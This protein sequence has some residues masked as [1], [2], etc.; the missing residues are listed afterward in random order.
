MKRLLLA[1]SLAI[2]ATFTALAG[3]APQKPEPDPKLVALIKKGAD[4]LDAAIPTLDAAKLEEAGNVFLEAIRQF[5]DSYRAA[6]GVIQVARLL[7]EKNE[8]GEAI[9]WMDRAIEISSRKPELNI[10]TADILIRAKNNSEALRRIKLAIDAAPQESRILSTSLVC[11]A[12]MGKFD[13]ESRQIAERL[14]TL[15]DG[16]LGALLFLGLWNEKH[17]NLDAARDCY[18]KAVR[19]DTNNMQARR[20][21][22][23]LYDKQ[24]NFELAEREFIKM[25]NAAPGHF[26][27]YLYLAELYKKH[28]DTQLAKEFSD[29]A[30]RLKD[31][32]E[33][34]QNQRAVAGRLQPPQGAPAAPN[35]EKGID[36]GDDPQ[37]QPK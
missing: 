22:G 10:A 32:A 15:P 8:A 31:E 36:I 16:Q 7:T 23:K 25:T 3:E 2:L 37:N 14:Q 13:D 30:Q 34:A 6:L 21:L 1:I 20:M 29:K 19:L 35:A 5:P 33:K 28:G 4:I 18:L 9:R 12:D 26:I 11:M 24:N 17:D 27:G